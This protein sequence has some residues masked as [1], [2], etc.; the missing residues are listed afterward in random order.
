LLLITYCSHL[1]KTFSEL[2]SSQRLLLH[3][4]ALLFT[5]TSQELSILSIFNS[6]SSNLSF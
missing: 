2:H 4:L 3:L 5:R 1:M 6:S